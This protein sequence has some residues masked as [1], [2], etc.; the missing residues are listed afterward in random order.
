[1]NKLKLLVL[2][3][4]FNSCSKS[5]SDT[6]V[7]SNSNESLIDNNNSSANDPVALTELRSGTFV[8]SVSAAASDVLVTS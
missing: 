4:L 6:A 1:M 7:Y 8:F 5:D 3:I 2:I